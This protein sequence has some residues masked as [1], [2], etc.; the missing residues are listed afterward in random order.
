MLNLCQ[1]GLLLMCLQGVPRYAKVYRQSF[2]LMH[3]GSE[4]PKRTTLFSCSPLV[5]KLDRG[6]LVIEERKAKTKLQTTRPPAE[7]AS[8][9]YIYMAQVDSKLLRPVSIKD[10]Y[11]YIKIT[12]QQQLFY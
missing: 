11:I 4:S 2:W 7:L 10:L 6:K 9:I 5:K 3:W 1:V 12:R 8:Y